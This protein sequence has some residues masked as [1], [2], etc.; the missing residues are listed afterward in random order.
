MS[1]IH[2]ENCLNHFLTFLPNGD[3]FPCNRFAD[4]EQFKLG[5]ITETIFTEILESKKRTELLSRTVEEIDSCKKCEFKLYCKGGCMN[6]AYEFYQT[7]Y[8]RDYYC[9]AF[10]KIFQYINQHV[11][12]SIVKAKC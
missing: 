9:K 2:S 10:F 3:V 12:E 8:E 1:C 11:N 6:H 4:Y 7:I 5:N